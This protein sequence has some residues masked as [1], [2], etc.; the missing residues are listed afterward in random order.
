MFKPQTA[1]AGFLL[2]LALLSQGC[3]RKGPLYMRLES[4]FTGGNIPE[5]IQSEH[6][7]LLDAM[8]QRDPQ[9]ARLAM[10]MHMKN[11]EVRFASNWKVQE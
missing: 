2:L 5:Q 6:E 8:L 1:F 11:A 7:L 10:Q 3:G 4:H 9:A